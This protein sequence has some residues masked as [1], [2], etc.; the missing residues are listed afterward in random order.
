MNFVIKH[1]AF[2]THL[3]DQSRTFPHRK[4]LFHHRHMSFI[5]LFL[6]H[7]FPLSLE[8]HLSDSL[9][10]AKL[11]GRRP[12]L[13][14]TPVETLIAPICALSPALVVLAA[15]VSPDSVYCWMD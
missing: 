4:T 8:M 1:L 12:N 5:L 6:K 2:K 3:R 11:G 9:V 14:G 13:S 10:L 7:T 15:S